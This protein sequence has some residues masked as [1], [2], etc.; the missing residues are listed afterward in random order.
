MPI[1]EKD[2]LPADVIGSAI[3]PV[4]RETPGQFHVEHQQD[5]FLVLQRHG[6]T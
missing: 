4:P 5:G 1:E 3:L 2:K 6:F